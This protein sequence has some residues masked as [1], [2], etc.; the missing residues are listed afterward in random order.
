MGIAHRLADDADTEPDGQIRYLSSILDYTTPAERT[1]DLLALV[2]SVPGWKMETFVARGA[3]LV[4]VERELRG[5]V[6]TIA[7][8]WPAP[9]VR[10]RA[11]LRL[12]LYTE[13]K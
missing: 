7:P 4:N 10:D 11:R 12:A 5:H 1:A 3:R 13:G 9:R 8:Q 2:N 6:A